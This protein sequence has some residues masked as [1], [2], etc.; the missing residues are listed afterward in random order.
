MT[1]ARDAPSVRSSPNSRVRW[2][3]VIENVLKMMNAPTT[4][5]TYAN[6]SRNV[7]RKLRFDSRSEVSCA[8]CSLPVRTCTVCGSSARIRARSS[9]GVTPF[10]AATSIW[11]KRPG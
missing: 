1:W 6:T 3:T 9:A 7:R 11:S 10:V 8:A 5:A 2:A 4:S